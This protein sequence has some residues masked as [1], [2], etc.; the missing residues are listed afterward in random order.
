MDTGHLQ[1]FGKGAFQKT[2]GGIGCFLWIVPLY[3]HRE[4]DRSHDSQKAEDCVGCRLI[5]DGYSYRSLGL[6]EEYYL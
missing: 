1:A 2:L 4:A 6:S 5:M 3:F